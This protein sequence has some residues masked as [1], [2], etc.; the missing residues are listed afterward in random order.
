ME[1]LAS[2]RLRPLDSFYKTNPPPWVADALRSASGPGR[3]PND[4]Q[5]SPSTMLDE[6]PLP[7]TNWHS[8]RP[9]RAQARTRFAGL[10]L[11][12]R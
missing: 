6:W 3:E 5:V 8:P 4:R 9:L 1:T 7:A 12:A 10:L 11:R 2:P